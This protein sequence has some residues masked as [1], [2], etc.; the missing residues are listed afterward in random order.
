MPN[1]AGSIQ[2][3]NEAEFGLG[4]LGT[5]SV[6]LVG[7]WLPGELCVGLWVGV[8]GGGVYVGGGVRVYEDG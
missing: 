1:C 4:P 5:W 8:G 2:A 6:S 7:K 3:S